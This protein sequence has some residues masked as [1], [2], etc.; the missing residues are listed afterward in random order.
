MTMMVKEEH[1]DLLRE[2]GLKDEDFDKFDGRYVRYEFDE[3]RGVRI[4]DPWYQTS[5]NEYIDSDGWSAWSDEEDTF[6]SDM[7]KASRP[8]VE[9]SKISHAPPDP[10]DLSDAP[11]K[12]PEEKDP[13]EAG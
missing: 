2:L 11:G 12:R 5:Y 3:K 7:L 1:K 13:E 4:Y 10:E 9:A 6:M 8:A